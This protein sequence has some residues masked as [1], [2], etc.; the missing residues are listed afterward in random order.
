MTLRCSEY[1]YLQYEA[2]KFI[3]NVLQQDVNRSPQAPLHSRRPLGA[4]TNLSR[5][6]AIFNLRLLGMEA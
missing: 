1:S 3:V 6:L 5:R 4:G 2:A